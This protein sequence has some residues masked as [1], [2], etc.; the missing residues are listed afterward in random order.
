[1]TP[2]DTVIRGGTAVDGTRLTRLR[3]DVGIR[4]GRNADTARRRAMPGR[5]LRNGKIGSALHRTA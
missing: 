2:F 5:L 4:D 3:A 1:M